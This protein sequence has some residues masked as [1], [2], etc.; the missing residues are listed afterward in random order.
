MASEALMGG[1]ICFGFC[2]GSFP[3][4]A[5]LAKARQAPF[6]LARGSAGGFLL[7]A[8]H[9]DCAAFFEAL[10]ARAWLTPCP[11][12]SSIPHRDLTLSCIRQVDE[13]LGRDKKSPRLRIVKSYSRWLIDAAPFLHAR[14]YG[15]RTRHVRPDCGR[16]ARVR[17]EQAPNLGVGHPG[18]VRFCNRLVNAPSVEKGHGD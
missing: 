11:K 6:S 4:G 17:F 3:S 15:S 12:T 5:R 2:F 8:P 14:R 1:A 7:P 18:F 16:I 10:Q 9:C 13:P